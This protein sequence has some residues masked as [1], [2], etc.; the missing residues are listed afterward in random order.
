MM[1][2]SLY[3]NC[4]RF[5]DIIYEIVI[6]WN[7]PHFDFNF[8]H[9]LLFIDDIIHKIPIYVY[10]Q[11]KNSL[12][13]R[14][15][16]DKYH[17]FKTSSAIFIDDDMFINEYSISCMLHTFY[18]NPFKIIA[19][20][21]THLH[22]T[23]QFEKSKKKWGKNTKWLYK[24]KHS[25]KFNMLLPGMSMFNT[26]YLP[27]LAQTLIEYN[28]LN[29]IDE[30]IA[31]CDDIS[32]MLSMSMINNGNKYLFGIDHIL[33]T[34][35]S[36]YRKQRAMTDKSHLSLRYKQ[37]SECLTMIMNQ[38]VNINKNKRKSI[39]N[40]IVEHQRPFDTIDC[41]KCTW[42]DHRGCWNPQKSIHHKK[43]TKIK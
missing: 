18:L 12:A 22:T 32:M 24:N 34:D 35:Y 6:V 25:N 29:I 23:R 42:C 8:S 43:Q 39:I 16:I 19:P 37:R 41:H 27:K 10:K 3:N 9:N 5:G 7:S 38:F 17:K 13:N 4:Y 30:Q 1:V 40:P 31:H 26:A 36:Q 21:H 28:L 20:S 14:W 33:I 15:F 2:L 11:S